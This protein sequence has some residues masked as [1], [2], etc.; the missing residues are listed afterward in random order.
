[1]IPWKKG[2][3][4]QE[5]AQAV[6]SDPDDVRDIVRQLTMVD[7]LLKTDVFNSQ[8]YR[9]IRRE[10]LRELMRHGELY[11]L[12]NDVTGE[13]S[14][15]LLVRERAERALLLLNEGSDEVLETLTG[16]LYPNVRRPGTDWVA[17]RVQRLID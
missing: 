6:G 17:V 12:R 11:Q 10:L 15:V 2:L 1:M 4:R 16:L 14:P 3:H 7:Q 9:H 8:H 13:I 5:P